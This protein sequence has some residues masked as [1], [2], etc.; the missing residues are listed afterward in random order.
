MEDIGALIRRHRE[1]SGLTLADVEKRTGIAQSNLSRVE[2]GGVE[3][4]LSTLVRIADAL[5]C[6]ITLVPR[7]PAISLGRLKAQME[8]SR[9]R[10][11]R[12]GLGYSDPWKRLRQKAASGEDVS[13]E[14]G[15]LVVR[16]V[17]E[18]P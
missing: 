3:P 11:L 10:V 9:E 1:A 13:T 6:D 14:I 12:A 8:G 2:V 4:R 18:A 17:V 15:S 5:D 16:G 7:E